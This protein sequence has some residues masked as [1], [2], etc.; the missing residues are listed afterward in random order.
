VRARV[1]VVVFVL[2]A[3]AG[4]ARAARTPVTALGEA[5]AAFQAG[6]YPL[7]Y[8]LAAPLAG[9]RLLNRDHA[10]SLAAR[11][12]QRRGQPRVALRLFERL[13]RERDSGLTGLA[14]WGA[15]DCL[16][17]LGRTELARA[18]Y[19]RLLGGEG[20]RGLAL[21]RIGEAHARARR[22]APAQAAW[23][24]LVLEHPDHALAPQALARLTAAGAPPLSAAERLA[25][26]R[27]LVSA[28]RWRE[29]VT[30]LETI[31]PDQPE[32]LRVRRDYWIAESLYRMRREYE[33]AA[34]LFL[35]VHEK[36]GRDGP[37]ALFKGARALSRADRDTEAIEWYHKL[38]ARYPRSS[39]ADEAQFLAGWL[40]FNRGQPQKG[41]P[42]LVKHRK[43][44]PRSRFAPD[45]SW[46]LGFGAYLAGD[47]RTALGYFAEL[48]RSG[49][50]LTGG[51]GAYWTARVLERL[52]RRDEALATLRALVGRF[53]LS[54]YALLARARLK[55]QGLAVGPFGEARPATVA[56][57]GRIEP[58]LGR[59]PGVQRAD[60]LCAAGMQAEAAQELRRVEAAL[61]ARHGSRLALPVL[62]HGYARAGDYHHAWKLA[63]SYGSSALAVPPEGGAR[64]WWELAYPLAYRPFVERHR[65]LGALP[66]YW[67]YAIM[68][69]ESGFD[70]GDVSYANAIGLM[71]MIPTTTQRV[72]A[73]L[74][75]T[76]T[77]DLLKDPELNI[78]VASWYL[79][80][81]WRQA[82]GQAPVAAASYNGGP[83]AMKRFLARNGDR[84][85]DEFVELI[86]YQQSREYAKK[87]VALY[88]RYLYL[89]EREVYEQPL[90]VEREYQGEVGY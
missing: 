64:P 41:V 36:V 8:R 58:R 6:D 60:E 90:R 59:E 62:F 16:F 51:K 50:E 21:F 14:R 75:M 31:G 80:H 82:R 24:R 44:F 85:M 78:K 68:L 76:Y 13:A 46:Y 30:E 19:E 86:S 17:A 45:A 40:E 72:A 67:L 18:Q 37:E 43:L 39:F 66:Q 20:D 55:E 77:D 65:T 89:Y 54:W 25:R 88:A 12:A 87:V 38:V 34:R 79:G 81:L 9:G 32:E 70:P 28:R 7:A 2:V 73:A 15:A 49:K 71:Q 53:P 84:P 4:S 10:L 48:A 23:R 26:A 33:R 42:D 35:A 69:K 56:P 63:T 52:G 1:T 83:A 47:D 74:K 27:A 11:A 3:A 57:P 5:H 61:I 29:A 22:A